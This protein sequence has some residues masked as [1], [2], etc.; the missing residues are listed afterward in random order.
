MG[1][2]T[3]MAVPRIADYKEAYKKWNDTKPLRGRSEDI[4][5]LGERRDVDTYSIRKN[6]WT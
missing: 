6:I 3:V 1:Y 2:Q 5:P 4:R